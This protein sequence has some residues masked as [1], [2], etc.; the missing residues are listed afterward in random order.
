[1]AI[2]IHHHRW[3]ALIGKVRQG[4]QHLHKVSTESKAQDR[5][6]TSDTAPV[7]EYESPGGKCVS[8]VDPSM[9]SHKNVWFW[10]ETG[11][12]DDIYDDGASNNIR[13]TYWRA[14]RTTS[15]LW[16]A[17][18]GIAAWFVATV[19]NN[20]RCQGAR[21]RS[22]WSRNRR[23]PKNKYFSAQLSEGLPKKPLTVQKLSTQRFTARQVYIHLYP[24]AAD[25]DELF[26]SG[27]SLQLNEHA[28]IILSQPVELL[29]LGE[30]AIIT[31]AS[32]QWG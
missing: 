9:P 2:E 19:G 21:T 11:G 12:R 27:R 4:M 22:K 31:Q 6:Q 26:P 15:V 30:R 17:I 14:T 3:S 10:I 29:G 7:I 5:A 23:R 18:C 20:R 16:I 8:T 24:S 13:G 1:M 28:G 25:G 32:H